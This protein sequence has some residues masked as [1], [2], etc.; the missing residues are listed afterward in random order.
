MAAESLEY[1]VILFGTP[2]LEYPHQAKNKLVSV[3]YEW[4]RSY[5]GVYY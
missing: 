5:W 3:P 2:K 4:G 1:G